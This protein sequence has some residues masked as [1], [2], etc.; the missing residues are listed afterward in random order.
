MPRT[1]CGFNDDPTSGAKGAD[2]LLVFGPTILVDIG[3]D[4][5]FKAHIPGAVPKLSAK[6]LYALIDTGATE[7]CIDGDLANQLSLPVIDRRPISGVSGK[8]EVNMHLAQIHIPS[9]SFT[10]FGAFAAVE[11]AAGGQ[12][13]RALIG[14]TFLRHFTMI[15]NGVTGD[16]ELFS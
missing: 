16:V 14:R 6:S 15:Y 8:K 13:H 7:S 11:L 2:S 3:F 1:K 4:G 9:L 12:Q 10:I 5:D